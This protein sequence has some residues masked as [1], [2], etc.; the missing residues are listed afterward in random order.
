MRKRYYT[1]QERQIIRERAFERCEYCQC[2]EDFASQPFQIEHI[3]PVSLNG[4]SV[5]E[6]LAYSCGGCNGHKYN[7]IEAPDPADN[8]LAPLYNPRRDAWIDHFGWNEDYSL[9]IGLTPTGRATVEALNLNRRG[10]TNIRQM[11]RNAGKHPP[12]HL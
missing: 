6:N 7:K 5:L 12:E 1:T 11:L 10:V 3:V 8:K 4:E 2:P 9:V